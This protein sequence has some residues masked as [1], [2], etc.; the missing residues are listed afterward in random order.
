MVAKGQ[1]GWGR[2]GSGMWDLQ[3]QTIICRIEKQQGPTVPHRDLYSFS[4]NH[5]GKEHDKEYACITE[6]LGCPR[7]INTA[8]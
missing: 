3:M 7:E 4:V 8:L 1:G 5:N 2:D 6:S